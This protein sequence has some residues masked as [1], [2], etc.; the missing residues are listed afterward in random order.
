MNFELRIMNRKGRVPN[1][2]WSGRD[3]LLVSICSQIIAFYIM[4]SHVCKSNHVINLQRLIFLLYL[5]V[6]HSRF[7]NSN[8]PIAA[9]YANK[10]F[11]IWLFANFAIKSVKNPFLDSKSL[12]F[13]VLIWKHPLFQFSE[14]FSRSKINNFEWAELITMFIIRNSLGN[15]F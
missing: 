15:E 12:K 3:F 10:L 13:N 1:N 9:K 7:K 4:L 14:K 11:W 2:K 5:G 8:P 6:Y